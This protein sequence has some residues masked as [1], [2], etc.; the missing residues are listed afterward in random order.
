[1]DVEEYLLYY[2]LEHLLFEGLVLVLLL[3]VLAGQQLGQDGAARRVAYVF[4]Q[5]L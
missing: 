3:F 1:V 4:Y 2:L 5:K